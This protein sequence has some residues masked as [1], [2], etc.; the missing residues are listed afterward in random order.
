MVAIPANKTRP[1]YDLQ[2][3]TPE[4]L[5]APTTPAPRDDASQVLSLVVVVLSKATARRRSA[6][7]EREEIGL[8]DHALTP[9]P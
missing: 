7:L 8:E 3:P 1:T 5:S 2:A 9:G 6:L 4:R